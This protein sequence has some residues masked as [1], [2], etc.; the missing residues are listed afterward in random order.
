MYTRNDTWDPSYMML[1][2]RNMAA[3][4]VHLAVDIIDNEET[5]EPYP[6]VYAVPGVQALDAQEQQG[7]SRGRDPSSDGPIQGL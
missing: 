7:R 1:L 4:V 6:N 5:D 2:Q 3:G